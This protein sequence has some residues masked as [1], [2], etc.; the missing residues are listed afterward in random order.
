MEA[1]LGRGVRAAELE[2]EMP[3]TCECAGRIGLAR[4]GYEVVDA[5][6]CVLPALAAGAQLQ[7]FGLDPASPRRRGEHVR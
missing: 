3:G 2:V 6:Q 1:T 5:M 7:V 4:R